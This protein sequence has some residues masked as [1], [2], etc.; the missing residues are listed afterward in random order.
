[1]CNK[2]LQSFEHVVR[3]V[4]AA[5]KVQENVIDLFGNLSFRTSPITIDLIFIESYNQKVMKIEYRVYA[6][7]L[8]RIN[9]YFKNGKNKIK[10]SAI[11]DNNWRWRIQTEALTG[12]YANF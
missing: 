10:P 5:K 1:M 11:G 7:N 12:N 2:N 6:R 8:G 9:L 3:R 4:H